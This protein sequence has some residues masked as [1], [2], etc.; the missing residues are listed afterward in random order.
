MFPSLHGNFLLGLRLFFCLSS[1]SANEKSSFPVVKVPL[2][3]KNSVPHLTS[4]KEGEAAQNQ[5]I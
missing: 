5:N 3:K 2:K 1:V 4:V